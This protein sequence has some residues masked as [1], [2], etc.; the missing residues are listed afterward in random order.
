VATITPDGLSLEG[1]NKSN[2]EDAACYNLQ[3]ATLKRPDFILLSE[4]KE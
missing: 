4:S 1:S 3:D 2:G